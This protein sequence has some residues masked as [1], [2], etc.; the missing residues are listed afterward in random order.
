MNEFN[1]NYYS[2]RESFKDALATRMEDDFVLNPALML[3]D[4]K[5]QEK[6]NILRTKISD[7]VNA[8]INNTEV[9]KNIEN[10]FISDLDTELSKISDTQKREEIKTALTENYGD[11]ATELMKKIHTQSKEA[12]LQ[13]VT[14]VVGGAKGVAA[15]FNIEKFTA[16]LIDTA[17]VGIVNGVLGFQLGKTIFNNESSEI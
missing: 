1:T 12:Y 6:F 8:E 14:T 3:A 4:P 15:T 7:E 11:V 5:A 10:K 16:K 9:E 13:S 2:A 17:S